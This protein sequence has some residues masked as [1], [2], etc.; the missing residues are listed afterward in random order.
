MGKT[1]EQ[2][3]LVDV[4]SALHATA[5]AVLYLL[6]QPKTKPEKLLRAADKLAAALMNTKPLIEK[7]LELQE[8][9]KINIYG[10]SGSFLNELEDTTKET[11]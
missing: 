10:V 1:L 9:E 7:H 2:V 6:T 3:T 4:A 11:N 8:G 5:G